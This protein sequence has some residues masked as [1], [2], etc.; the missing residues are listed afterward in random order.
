VP[1]RHFR[2]DCAGLVGFRDYLARRSV[3]RSSDHLRSEIRFLWT[4]LARSEITPSMALLIVAGSLRAS[5]GK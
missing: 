1:S 5:S 4:S 2:H 3:T